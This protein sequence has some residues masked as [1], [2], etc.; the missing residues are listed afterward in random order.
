MQ[1]EPERG[2]AL[3]R[4]R[5]AYQAIDFGFMFVR[6]Y[7]FRLLAIEAALV[8][9]LATL[10][11]FV[12]RGYTVWVF[13]LM[14]WL[15]PIW[16][17]ALLFSLSRALF[18]DAPSL[19]E[20]LREF[21]SY[22]FRDWLPALTIRRF[23]P[24]RS[25][26][27]PITVLEGSRGKERGARLAVLHRGRFP[28]AAMALTILLAHVEVAI[29]V[30]VVLFLQML[31]PETVEWNVLAWVF[32]IEG[33]ATLSS[34]LFAYFLDLAV[35]LSVAPFYV[36]AGFSLYLHRRTELEA[37]DIEQAFRRMAERVREPRMNRAGIARTLAIIGFAFG[38]STLGIGAGGASAE[39]LTR[40]SAK[41]SVDG[42]LEGE[43]F[44]QQDTISVPKFILDWELDAQRSEESRLPKWLVNFTDWL[45][46]I[47]GGGL[48]ILI[49]SLVLGLLA[50]LI[51]RI[52]GQRGLL[53]LGRRPASQRRSMPTILF[54]L[55]VTEASL[56][57]DLVGEAAG[58]ARDGRARDALAL[59][60]RGALTRLAL[61][62]GAELTAGVTERECLEAA[63]QLLPGDG[64]HYFEQLTSTWM[65]CA[66]GH[67]DPNPN[68]LESLCNRWS[69]WFENRVVSI[70][71]RDGSD[72]E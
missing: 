50:W 30:S 37:W 49:V 68:G 42:I 29:V 58:A 22:G 52:A 15:K 10:L 38:V 6:Q 51:Y 12:F 24:T 31:V 39:E 44:Y 26:D 48:E 40:E 59:L 25:L 46:G 60:Y 4:P 8:L 27:L 33:D 67:I 13:G 32:V 45:G 56:P 2:V 20:T 5:S 54:G 55:E 3:L 64:T 62:Y 72:S 53:D 14:W 57:D 71:S 23:S 70:E 61:V 21:R 19:R 43:A 35:M 28:S 41:A 36:A 18:E 16:E 66:Y 1:A 65:R 9:P 34:Q 63:R 69:Q 17:R 11:A 7:Y 47:I